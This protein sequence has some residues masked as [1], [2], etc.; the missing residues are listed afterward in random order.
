MR[1][2]LFIIFAIALAFVQRFFIFVV[3]P[4]GITVDLILLYIV[5]VSL[6]SPA[7]EAVLVAGLCGFVLDMFSPT[8]AG[9]FMLGYSLSGFIL[10]NS[11]DSLNLDRPILHGIAILIIGLCVKII[12]MFFYRFNI[13]NI[14]LFILGF[15]IT[16]LL[17]S[18]IAFGLD[19]TFRLVFGQLSF[20]TEDE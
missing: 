12:Q 13:E 1:T 14:F 18:L 17:T 4:L 3:T 15:V 9:C 19:I 11:R 6:R 16:Y 20:S 10:S 8:S 7:W 2:I 5:F